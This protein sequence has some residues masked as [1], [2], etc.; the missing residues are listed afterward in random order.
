MTVAVLVWG[1][2]HSGGLV[3][4]QS[5]MGRDSVD[6]PEFGN[7]LFISFSNLGI[8]LGTATGGL[9]LTHLGTR[10]LVWAGVLFAALAL[11]MIGAR[12]SLGRVHKENGAKVP[13]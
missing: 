2:V 4:S 5:W 6:A 7:S 12:L 11:A 13:V 10:Q 3:I 9:F 1:V 8:T